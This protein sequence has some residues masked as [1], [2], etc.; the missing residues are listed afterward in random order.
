MV[1]VNIGGED[2]PAVVCKAEGER[3]HLYLFTMWRD[4]PLPREVRAM[5][6]SV[7]YM[8]EGATPGDGV[9]QYRRIDG[10]DREADGDRL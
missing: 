8:I 7:G 3:L 10:A 9:G 4:H 5:T 1:L 2:R 6:S